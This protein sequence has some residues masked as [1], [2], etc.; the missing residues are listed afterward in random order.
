M[1]NDSEIQVIR[2]SDALKKRLFKDVADERRGTFLAEQFGGVLEGMVTGAEF[3]RNTYEWAREAT[4][5]Y[6]AAIWGFA[7]T[8]ERDL[9]FIYPIGDNGELFGETEKTYKLDDWDENITEI[10]AATF[11]LIASTSALNKGADR[12]MIEQH[13]SDI[14][15]NKYNEIS[16]AFEDA[17]NE[18]NET[19]SPEDIEMNNKLRDYY[20]SFFS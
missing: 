14:Y 6:T 17:V 9:F 8:N 4:E 16:W 20:Y 12:H 7:E 11:G 15:D 1:N 2:M 18:I 13:L 5:D 10:D 19:A 3:E